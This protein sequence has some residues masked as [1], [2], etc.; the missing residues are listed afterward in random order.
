LISKPVLL[1]VGKG[2]G[3]LTISN[4]CGSGMKGP[5]KHIIH[6]MSKY[7]LVIL[8]DE[9]KTSWTCHSCKNQVTH[10]RVISD[11]SKNKIES[12]KKKKRKCIYYTYGKNYKR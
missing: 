4:V 5:I 7:C 8:V 1:F 6:E 9:F 3:S 12:E 11:I 2:N 10:V